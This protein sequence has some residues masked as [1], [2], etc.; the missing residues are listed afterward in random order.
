MPDTDEEPTFDFKEYIAEIKKNGLFSKK[1]ITKGEFMLIA[2]TL[3]LI[4]VMIYIKY[5]TGCEIDC[6]TC[7]NVAQT[8][9]QTGVIR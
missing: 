6:S 8:I 4:G 5:S 3:I 2:L 7:K 9:K 1:Q